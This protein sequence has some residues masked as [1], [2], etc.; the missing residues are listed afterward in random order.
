MRI[1]ILGT[2]AVGG[3]FGALLSR[4]GQEVA[5]IARGA[6]LD[7]I[8]THG[9]RLEGPRGDFTVSARATDSPAEIGP[10]DYV[11][12]C[13]K[14][15]DA[16][17]AAELVK[18][19]VAQGGVCISLM[20]G[21]DGQDRLAPILG[22]DRVMG[23]LAFVA[24]VIERPGLI[25]YTS[26]MSSIVFGEADGRASE[27][28][29]RLRDAC[30]AAGFSAEVSTD[31]RA[32]QWLK[33][34]GLATNTALTALTRQPTG[35]VYHDA[36][37]LPFAQAALEEVVAVATASGVVLPPGTAE[38][39]LAGLKKFPPSMSASMAN[40]LLR[41]RRLELESLSGYIVRKGRE[42]GVATPVH[43]FAYAC[44]KPY[45]NGAAK[46]PKENPS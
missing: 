27:R 44:L 1:T 22:A 31:V 3:Y 41:G 37:M 15:Y 7:A 9:L 2:G 40:D 8:R 4:A 43:A 25:R 16:E 20:N 14:Q 11:L 19:L 28:A 23:G 12:F 42:L 45:L 34:V 29:V 17:S 26:D 33:F 18:P 32:A 13:E 30:V 35:Y 21:V 10:V 5:F 46:S 24:G 38:R 39:A 6:H 36:D